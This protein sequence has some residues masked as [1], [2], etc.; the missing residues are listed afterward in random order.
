M[1]VLLACT[2]APTPLSAPPPAPAPA[3]APAPDRIDLARAAA[4]RAVGWMASRSDDTSLE[5]DVPI[6]LSA[7]A[8]RLPSAEAAAL[9]AR[10][11]PRLDREGDPRRRAYEP[12][13]RLP[14]PP[15]PAIGGGGEPNMN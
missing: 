12:T 10:L 1:V 14:G 15:P 7:I 13:A 3:Q 2:S 6:G 11:R 8:A 9:D 5:L 4:D